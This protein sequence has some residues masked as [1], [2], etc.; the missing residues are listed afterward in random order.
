M[1]MGVLPA[2]MSV[3]RVHTWYL[4]RPEESVSLPELVLEMVVNHHLDAVN[5]IQVLWKS[6]QCLKPLSH[7]SSELLMKGGVL[8]WT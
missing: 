8:E 2:C 7:L 1:S 3:Y 4:W 5:P 6:S